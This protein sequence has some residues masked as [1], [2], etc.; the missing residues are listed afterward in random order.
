MKQFYA[1]L[2]DGSTVK[3]YADRFELV[4][5]AIRGVYANGEIVAYLDTGAVLYAHIHGGR[6]GD[7]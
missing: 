3:L 1:Q 2:S 5:N 7:A 6:G 4:D